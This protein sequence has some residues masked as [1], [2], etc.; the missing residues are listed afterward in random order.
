ML[1]IAL[2]IVSSLFFSKL[3]WNIMVPFSLEWKRLSTNAKDPVS[4]SLATILEIGLWL[5][6][7]LLAFFSNGSDW[8][9]SPKKI[10][11]WG[12]CAILASYVCMF[13]L[14][15]VLAWFFEGKNGKKGRGQTP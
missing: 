2:F 8:L 14:G 6:W 12:G 5:L 1:T 11:G 15:N 13:A 9:H 4:M 3:A 7:M 10:A